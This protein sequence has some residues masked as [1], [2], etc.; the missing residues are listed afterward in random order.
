MK[1]KPWI[2]PVALMTCFVG[3]GRSAS[4]PLVSQVHV[5]SVHVR[6]RATFDAV[7]LFFKNV[8]QLPLVYGALSKPGNDTRTSYAGFSVGNAYLEPCGPYKNDAPYLPDQ[9]ARFHGLT[10]SPA[11]SMADAV[12]ELGSRNLAYSGPFGGGS[13]PSFVYLSD[14]LLAGQLL[15]VSIW[16]LPKKDDRAN[17]PFLSAALEEA[18]G[19]PLGVKRL[20]EV[21]IGHPDPANPTRWSGFLNPA[22]QEAEAWMVGAGPRFRFVPAKAL[23]VESILLKVGSLEKARAVLASNNLLGKQTSDSLELDTAKTWGL[24]IELRQE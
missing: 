13:M 10:F 17:L 21:R 6:D 23:Q 15:A 9:P 8:L 5:V 20:A 22:K 11:G 2:I 7:F 24:R 3:I 12:R 4:A 16:E 19:G 14:P 18:K 1:I